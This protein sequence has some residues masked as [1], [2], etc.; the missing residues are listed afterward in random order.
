MCESSLWLDLLLTSMMFQWIWHSCWFCFSSPSCEEHISSSLLA[1]LVPPPAPT[2]FFYTW[3]C[4]QGTSCL[5]ASSTLTSAPCGEEHCALEDTCA[6]L[7]ELGS[8][9]CWLSCNLSLHTYILSMLSA[10]EQS[11]IWRSAVG[12]WLQP[13]VHSQKR[14]IT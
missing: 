5:H 9:W 10:V 4:D 2:C 7:P 13:L 1:P 14:Y 12:G 6:A 8:N 3:G 11:R